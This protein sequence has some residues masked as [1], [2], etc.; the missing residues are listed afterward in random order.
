VPFHRGDVFASTSDG[1]QEYTPTG[2][3]VQTISG[4][5]GATTLCFDPSGQHLILPGVG[6]FDSSGDVLSSSWARVSN[7]GNDCVADGLGNVYT[8]SAMPDSSWVI[9]RYDLNGN[10]R[11]TF[12]LTFRAATPL[13]MDLAPDECTMYFGAFANNGNGVG[14]LVNVCTNTQGS[15]TGPDD[16]DDLRVLPNWEL[17]KLFDG[18]ARLYDTTGQ[19][20][21]S[22][23]PADALGQF[24]TMSLDPD[25]ASFWTCCA[26]DLSSTPS[27]SDVWRFDI[28]SGQLVARW[29]LSAG[30]IAVYSPPLFGDPNVEARVDSNPTGTAEA[31]LTR[32]RDSGRL[33]RI[34]VYIDSSSTG[35][36]VVVG[37]YSDRAGRPAQLQEQ[38]TITNV[39]SGSWNYIDVPS[40]PVTA[41]QFYW[42]AV[43]GPRGGGTVAFR[44]R[45]LLGLATV[46]AQ[47]DLTALPQHWSAGRRR[48]SGPLSAFES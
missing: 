16:F 43:L 42:V 19:P 11:E 8:S 10:V 21:Q 18:G 3:L 33:T 15:G 1:V 17:L 34:H 12:P 27:V 20:I 37:I 38:G 5:S 29:P 48:L 47:H 22:Y 26:L 28:N 32:V 9:T 45:A 24:R 4:T 14:P 23:S 46:S 31:F 30:A 13:A 41:G 44:H 35:H 36:N 39:R 2:Q 40:T 6:L 7:G 25:G